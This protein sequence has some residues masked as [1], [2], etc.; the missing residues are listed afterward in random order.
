MENLYALDQETLISIIVQLDQKLSAAQVNSLE[1]NNLQIMLSRAYNELDEMNKTRQYWKNK[2]LELQ[3]KYEPIKPRK[4]LKDIP[5]KEFKINV[6]KAI[7]Q[8]YKDEP[9]LEV[10][11]KEFTLPVRESSGGYKQEVTSSA[12]N[13]KKS[14]HSGHK[15]NSEVLVGIFP[16]G[17]VLEFNMVNDAKDYIR[18]TYKELATAALTNISRAARGS[19]FYTH[20]TAYNVKWSYKNKE[21]DYTV[22]G[23][24]IVK[25]I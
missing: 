1:Y 25:E 17:E 8:V 16:N 10:E 6:R 18:K 13:I 11:V 5:K 9:E 21:E 4:I 22:D 14:K 23:V 7:K 12:G 15:G 3:A 19:G 20:H 2:C 24:Q